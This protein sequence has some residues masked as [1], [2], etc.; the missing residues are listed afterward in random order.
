MG[1]IHMGV[2]DWIMAMAILGV[3]MLL[4]AFCIVAEIV[5][6]DEMRAL[7]FWVRG[8]SEQTGEPVRRFPLP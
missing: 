5:G 4:I 8:R 6:H 2:M 3:P 1:E 7:L